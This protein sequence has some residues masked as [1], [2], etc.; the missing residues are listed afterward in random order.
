LTGFVVAGDEAGWVLDR[1]RVVWRVGVDGI[2]TPTD[3]E[4][5]TY[6]RGFATFFDGTVV[7]AGTRCDGTVTG[8]HC[9]GDAVVEMRLLRES[10][11]SVDTVEL[12]REPGGQYRSVGAG[13]LGISDGGAWVYSD[14]GEL[15]T[16]D[17]EGTVTEL[18]IPTGAQTGHGNCM[19]DGELY[20]TRDAS[21]SA[22][23]YDSDV[24]PAPTIYES[25][26][27]SSENW[28][29]DRWDGAQW[30]PVDNGAHT[31]EGPDVSLTCTAEGYVIH[32]YGPHTPLAEWT[33]HQ[34]WEPSAPAIA[35]LDLSSLLTS[36]SNTLYTVSGGTLQRVDLTSD[37]LV[38]TPITEGDLGAGADGVHP[39]TIDIVDDA[40]KLLI[41]C[42]SLGRDA[43]SCLVTPDP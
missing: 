27:Q 32:P 11:A 41:A 1:N 40:G 35:P 10:D 34:G 14:T 39:A 18:R 9:D 42:T 13:V 25:G 20:G 5:P 8:E 43:A 22:E 28:V 4:I 7:F 31:S 38:A 24:G 16:V 33:P 26:A 2:A 19:V 3:A 29:V 12:F 37:R 21:A 6:N 17:A 15:S 36:T 23:T 30:V